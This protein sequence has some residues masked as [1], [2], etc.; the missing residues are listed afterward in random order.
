MILVMPRYTY[1][2]T[3]IENDWSKIPPFDIQPINVDAVKFV[4]SEKAKLDAACAWNQYVDKL[5]FPNHLTSQNIFEVGQEIT[6][7]GDQA[8]F[9]IANWKNR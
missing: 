8:R 6:W 4:N 9:A 2:W 3:V 5:P 7:F 1:S